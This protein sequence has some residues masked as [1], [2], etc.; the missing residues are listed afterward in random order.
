MP[1][2]AKRNSVRITSKQKVKPNSLVILDAAKLP[3]GP[4]VWPAFWTVGDNWPHGG[5]I[6]KVLAPKLVTTYPDNGCTCFLDI[7]EGVHEQPYNHATLH[8]TPGCKL[9]TPMLATGRVLA[10]NCDTSVNYNE[11]C[12]VEMNT[13]TSYGA[14]FNAVGGG[15]YGM[16]VFQKLRMFHST[17]RFWTAMYWN[18]GAIRVWNWPRA[19]IPADIKN[20]VPKPW[21]WGKPAARWGNVGP[22]SS[23]S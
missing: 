15:V 5:E 23:R 6:G 17:Q 18:S 8:T 12:G 14:G 19:R 16:L 22:Y 20:G 13:T 3:Y 10:T 1:N 9:R 11:G 21:T 4:T 2:G 7:V